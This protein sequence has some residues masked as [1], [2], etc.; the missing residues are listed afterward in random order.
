MKLYKYHTI[1]K[2]LVSALSLKSNWYSRL[3]NLNDPYEQAI[4]DL[5]FGKVYENLKKTF[6]VC[7]FSET[8]DEILMWSHY[9]DKHKGLCLEFDI[10]NIK[11]ESIHKIRY[12]NEIIEFQEVETYEDGSLK[13]NINKNGKFIL[14]K[15]KTWEYEKEWRRIKVDK[16]PSV[17]GL[18]DSWPG[19][20]SA[21]YFGKDCRQE[22]IELVQHLTSDLEVK[23]FKVDLDTH[24]F[25]MSKLSIV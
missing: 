2:N 22:D 15:F 18:Y 7:S 11:E 19:R 6:L 12:N 10:L 21:I 8:K 25:T 20:L 9:G 14:N 24:L 13:L 4:D 16:D 3:A 23:Y 1:N 17:K 5:T